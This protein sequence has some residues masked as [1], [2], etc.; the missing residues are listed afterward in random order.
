MPHHMFLVDFVQS[1]I[2]YRTEEFG[3][4]D[5]VSHELSIPTK[6]VVIA[7]PMHRFADVMINQGYGHQICKRKETRVAGVGFT[8]C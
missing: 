3:S 8:I 5:V 4:T 7:I 6:T 1:H 2:E